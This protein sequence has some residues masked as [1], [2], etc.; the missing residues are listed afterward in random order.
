[1]EKLTSKIKRNLGRALNMSGESTTRERV[2]ADETTEN[3]EFMLTRGQSRKNR[4]QNRAASTE[5]QRIR[6]RPLPTRFQG[7]R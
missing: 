6:T 2:D 7:R 1:V 4:E 3:M 5:G